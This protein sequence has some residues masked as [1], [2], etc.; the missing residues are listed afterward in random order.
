M[1]TDPKDPDRTVATGDRRDEL[2]YEADPD[3]LVKVRAIEKPGGPLPPEE[4]SGASEAGVQRDGP[5]I[6][7]VAVAPSG[8]SVW[9]ARPTED[10]EDDDDSSIGARAAH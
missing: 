4:H 1:T 8:P 10:D 5:P 6:Q 3:Q 2:H 7:D 9:D